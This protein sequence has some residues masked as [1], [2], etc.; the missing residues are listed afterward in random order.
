MFPPTR[1]ELSMAS[2]GPRGVTADGKASALVGEVVDA[3]AAPAV[4]LTDDELKRKTNALIDEFVI[5][6]DA[7]EAV[8]CV[9]ELNAP[10]FMAELVF[11]ALSKILDSI[12]ENDQAAIVEL[13]MLLFRTQCIT[14]ADVQSGFNV[15]AED[16]GDL[17]VDY[18]KAPKLVGDFLGAA[19]GEGALRLNCLSDAC[20]KLEYCS[21]RRE[22]AGAVFKAAQGKLG[23][24]GLS[25][26]CREETVSA[27]VLLEA[28]EDDGPMPSVEQWV[29]ENGLAGI[30]PL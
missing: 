23:D 6:R 28:T 20:E 7:K 14:A 11:T 30:V 1:G 8:Q 12:A 29:K 3:N 22:F 25:H 4:Q 19:V 17:S 24:Q 18:P 13:V 16:L 10:G 2:A 5:T 26:Q 15:F 21:Q 27:S 9:R